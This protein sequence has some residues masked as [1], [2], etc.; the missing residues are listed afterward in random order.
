MLQ[1]PS[2]K[3]ILRQ[4]FRQLLKTMS[5]DD[6]I[7]QSIGVTQRVVQHPKYLEAKRISVYVNLTNEISTRQII[8]NA[9]RMKKLVFIPRYDSNSMEMIRIHSLDDLDSLPKTKWN[10]AQPSLDDRTREIANGNLDLILTP[11]L[12]FS[13]D[14]SRLGHGK[15]FYDRFLRKCSIQTYTIGLAFRQ[16]IVSNGEIPMSETD[17]RLHEILVDQ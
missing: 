5:D 6:R 4:Q 11:G 9:F 10:I 12:A 13:N 15:A 3:Q 17:V 7:R 14:G 2:T 1:N 16:Q 8:E